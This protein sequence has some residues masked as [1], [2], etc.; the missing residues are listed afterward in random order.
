MQEKPK[1]IEDKIYEG[2]T[3]KLSA[4]RR[5]ESHDKGIILEALGKGRLV[6]T[7]A[8]KIFTASRSTLTEFLFYSKIT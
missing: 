5:V 1:T 6:Q 8:D 4:D 3:F 2:G 7:V